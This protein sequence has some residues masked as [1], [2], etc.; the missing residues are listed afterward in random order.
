M[1]PRPETPHFF[2]CSLRFP[3]CNPPVVDFS[4]LFWGRSSRF[5][6]ILRP[7]VHHV[8]GISDS[9]LFWWILSLVL[10]LFN[11]ILRI[12][13]FLVDI[14]YVVKML[15][16]LSWGDAPS[17]LHDAD[18]T[19]WGF[20]EVCFS[21][22]PQLC[23]LWDRMR[24]DKWNDYKY[25]IY[26]ILGLTWFNM[27]FQCSSDSKT[28]R[29]I[30]LHQTKPREKSERSLISKSC[31]SSVSASPSVFYWRYMMFIL[32]EIFKAETQTIYLCPFPSSGNI[33]LQRFR[34]ISSKFGLTDLAYLE[35]LGSP[36]EY[37]IRFCA[38]E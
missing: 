32:S 26:C 6:C 13:I 33:L 10:K 31:K 20:V 8:R 29:L 14:G 30:C 4:L 24:S 17:S 2:S 25:F 27:D 36:L 19:F 18:C 7:C 34:H 35:T 38:L 28:Q 1:N 16:R 37:K 11:L 9:L 23:G 3:L 15:E 21:A 22:D 5:I 12:L